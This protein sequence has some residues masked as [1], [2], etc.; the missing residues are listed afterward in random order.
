MHIPSLRIIFILVLTSLSLSS[1]LIQIFKGVVKTELTRH[2]NGSWS[3]AA[4][5]L[6]YVSLNH[7]NNQLTLIG[8]WKDMWLPS[9][10]ILSPA[11]KSPKAGAQTSIFCAVDQSL[12]GVAAHFIPRPCQGNFSILGV[13]PLL[14]GLCRRGSSKAGLRYGG[15]CEALGEERADCGCS[16]TLLH[17]FSVVYQFRIL[18]SR[19]TTLSQWGKFE[20]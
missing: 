9:Q 18:N 12:D 7:G 5:N 1:S 4:A 6:F 20:M 11:L 2:K 13:R 16:L 10:A 3:A 14:C 17:C 8:M 19:M 15:G